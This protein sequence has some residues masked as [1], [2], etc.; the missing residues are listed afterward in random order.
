MSKTLTKECE[1]IEI[2]SW[3]VEQAINMF[4]SLNSDGQPLRDADIIQAKLYAQAEGKSQDKD[5]IDLWQDLLELVNKLEEDKITDI[6][7]IL[8][9]QMYFERANRK[10]IEAKSGSIDVTVPGLRRYYT[11]IQPVILEQPV[12]LCNQLFNLAKIWEKVSKYPLFQILLKYGDNTRLFMGIY[13]H[14]FTVGEANYNKTRTIASCLLRLFTILELVETGFSSSLFKTFLFK[15]SLKLLDP[16][17][18]PKEIQTDFDQHIEE[19]WNRDEI[20]QSIKECD[21]NI[22]VYLNEY[23]YAQEHDQ[24]FQIDTKYDIEHIMP[25]SGRNLSR[26]RDDAGIESEREFADIVDTLGNKILLESGANR[27]IGNEWFRTKISGTVK[28]KTGYDGSQYPLAQ[29]LVETYRNN[30]KAYW[31]KQDIEE[32]TN[33][34]AQRITDFIFG[35]DYD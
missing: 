12:E 22:L 34:A 14:R 30:P 15:E 18:S 24:D 28:D 5:F 9:Q 3:Q 2:R 11:E 6:D 13:F 25:K 26:I 10:E 23:L 16:S 20:K 35:T 27:A 1:I 4:N 21:S 32:A 19:H 8:M 29:A 17:V 33:K 7:N 31:T